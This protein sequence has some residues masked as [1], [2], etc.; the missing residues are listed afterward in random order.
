MMRSGPKSVEARQ[1][2]AD[3]GRSKRLAA[4]AF[5]Q[6]RIDDVV[7][8]AALARRARAGIERHLVCGGIEDILLAPEDFLHAIAVMH[9]EIDDSH[10]LRA[11]RGHGVAS[12]YCGVVEETEAHGRMS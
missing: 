1:D 6:R 2:R 5:A 11:M 7:M 9:I 12:G 8:F 4:I 10:T 3:E